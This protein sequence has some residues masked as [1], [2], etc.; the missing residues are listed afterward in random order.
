M[1]FNTLEDIV[2]AKLMKEVEEDHILSGD[3]ALAYYQALKLA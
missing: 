1:E 2:L 3:E